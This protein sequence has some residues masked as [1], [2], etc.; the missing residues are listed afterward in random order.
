MIRHRGGVFGAAIVFVVVLV[1]IF[2]P[3]GA[4]PFSTLARKSAPLVGPVSRPSVMA[5]IRMSF[6]PAAFA[7]L[8]SA[9]RCS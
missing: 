6:T 2:A 4:I 8:H 5:W 1:A 7:A 3:L 9:M